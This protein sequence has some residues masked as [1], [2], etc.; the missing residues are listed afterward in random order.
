MH[1]GCL[2]CPLPLYIIISQ[3]VT[4]QVYV[5]RT[6]SSSDNPALNELKLMFRT[7]KLKYNTF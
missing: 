6:Q 5:S 1:L 7:L 2:K 3:Y 4:N